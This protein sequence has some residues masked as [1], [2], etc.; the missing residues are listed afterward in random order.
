MT[1][2]FSSTVWFG[3]ASTDGASLSRFTSIV[4]VSTVVFVPSV[5]EH[6]KTIAVLARPFR[7]GEGR[8]GRVGVAQDNGRAADLRPGVGE[9]LPSGSPPVAASVTTSFSST[10]WFAPAST[11]GASLSRLTSIVT[12]STVVFVPSLTLHW[13]TIAVFARPSG[14]VKVGEAAC[15]SLSDDARAARLRPGVGEALRFGIA[16]VRRA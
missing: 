7:R 16:A 14:A 15:A 3:P 11:V 9:S 1:T 4:T 10:A 12:V 13:N 5:T 2:S 6:W 8:R